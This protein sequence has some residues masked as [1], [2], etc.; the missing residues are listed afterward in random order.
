MSARPFT[1]LVEALHGVKVT[2]P[3]KIIALCP[4]H[5]DRH[6]SLTAREGDDG[7]VLLKCWAGCSADA[8]VGTLGLT[9]ADLFP[10][11][12]GAPGAGTSRE[13]RPWLAAD[14]LHLA[15]FEATVASVIACDLAAGRVAEVHRLLESARRLTDMM[16]A[17]NA[18]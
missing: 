7:R 1:R 17:A 10:P 6:P 2:G 15:A 14:L 4:A 16:E 12:P 9:L 3:G 13:R 11:R 5:P 8:V 18:R